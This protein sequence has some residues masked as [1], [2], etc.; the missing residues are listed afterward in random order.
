[1]GGWVDWVDGVM[2]IRSP[3]SPDRT[4]SCGALCDGVSGRAGGCVYVGGLCVGFRIV[5]RHRQARGFSSC[6]CHGASCISG[7]LYIQHGD[8]ATEWQTF[9]CLPVLERNSPMGRSSLAVKSSTSPSLG[10]LTEKYRVRG[11]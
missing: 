11:S 1:M 6:V 2:F 3:E 7:V 8:R 10:N 9:I 5:P 4:E